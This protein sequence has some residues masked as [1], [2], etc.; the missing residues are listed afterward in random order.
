[1]C[2]TGKCVWEN[3]MGDCRF[4]IYIKEINVKYGKDR[5][6]MQLSDYFLINKEIKKLEKIKLRKIKINS[7]KNKLFLNTYNIRQ[8]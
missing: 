8:K 6:N 5:C 3:Y 1:M 7:I 2:Y 4:P